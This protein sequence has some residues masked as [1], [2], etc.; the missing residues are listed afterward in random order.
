MISQV[1]RVNLA[2]MLFFTLIQVV[3]PLIPRYALTVSAS[4]FLIGLAVSAISITA[5]FL[6]PVSGFLSDS[7][8]R[9]KLMVLGLAFGSAAY[10]VLFLS[11]DIYQ[12]M[13]GRLLEGAGVALFVPS[14]MASAVDQA[15]EGKIGETLGWRSL[16]IG[17]G[18]T[19]GPALGGLLAEAF[20]YTTTFGITSVLILFLLPLVLYREPRMVKGSLSVSIK[21]LLEK[22]FVVAFV[23]LVVYAV[24]WMGLL[25]F[26]SAYLKIIGY[27]D[28]QIGLFVS[29]QA[30]SSLALR[31]LAGRAADRNPALMTYI[32][33]LLISLAFLLI[34]LNQEPLRL[35]IDAVIFG[36]GIGV[37][38]P[39]SQTL[40]LAH[41]HAGSRGFLSS[42]YT[43]G[44]DIGNMVG[45]LIFGA[46]IQASGSYPE[47]F[48]IAP[49]LTFIAALVVLVPE[50]MGRLKEN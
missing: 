31:I 16:M 17:L 11:T 43:M 50:R 22:H 40:A 42:I 39:G 12:I 45:P 32:G 10:L 18:F 27:G 25:T 20:G 7:W 48:L 38:V 34:A 29:I 3:V 37:F 8:A 5:I 13:L 49:V 19:V 9:S 1:W 2:T 6:R 47:S 35:Y 14:S 44:M 26:L 15:P 41:A 30:I 36:I 33:L 23:S 21:G 24:A 46:V 28:L 4:P